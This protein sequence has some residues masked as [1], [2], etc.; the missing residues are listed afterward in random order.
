[1]SMQTLG[2][3]FDSNLKMRV[4][5][6]NACQNAY[7]HLHNIRRIEKSP[8]TKPRAR[9]NMHLSRTRLTAAK[10]R[11]MDLQKILSRDSSKTQLP[12]CSEEIW[13]HNSCTCYT[14]LAGFQQSNTK[15]NSKSVHNF[16][17]NF[18]ARHL[19]ISNKW[20][21]HHN[22]EEIP[23]DPMK[24]LSWRFHNSSMII[25]QVCIVVCGPL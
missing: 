22:A 21:S 23:W 10:V 24:H 25:R 2:V 9:L 14:V 12:D 1:M 13:S 4:Q 11:W 18:M 19:A 8:A 6:T 3:T 20:P 5:N 7:L 16:Q 15:L 17:R